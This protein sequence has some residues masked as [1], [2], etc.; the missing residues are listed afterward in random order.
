ME[1]LSDVDTIVV[2]PCFHDIHFVERA[3]LVRRPLGMMYLQD[4]MLHIRGIRSA[5]RIKHVY[6][7]KHLDIG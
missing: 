3:A 4:T 6:E 2:S 1:R 7:K 5:T